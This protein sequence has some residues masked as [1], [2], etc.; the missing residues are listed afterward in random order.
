MARTTTMLRI[1]RDDSF[2]VDEITPILLQAVEVRTN[3]Y[4]FLRGQLPG[5]PG[6]LQ[7]LL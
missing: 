5:V 4:L 2:G 3:N 7:R 1:T 6:P